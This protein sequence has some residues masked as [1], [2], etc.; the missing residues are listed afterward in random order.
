MLGEIVNSK[1]LPSRQIHERNRRLDIARL[2]VIVSISIARK[3]V[4][5]G[6]FQPPWNRVIFQSI[7]R[8]RRLEAI[9]TERSK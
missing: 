6:G 9:A 8:I 7:M 4:C 1:T 5:S 3:N 2:P